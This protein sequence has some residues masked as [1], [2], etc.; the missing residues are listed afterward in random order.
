VPN[1]EFYGLPDTESTCHNSHTNNANLERTTG[2]EPA[3]LTLA[4]ASTPS[5]VFVEFV[6]CCPVRVWV[7][8]G[9]VLF[10]VFVLCRRLVVTFCDNR[11][12]ALSIRLKRPEAGRPLGTTRL[13]SAGARERLSRSEAPERW[14]P[15]SPARRSL[16]EVSVSER[17][18]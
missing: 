7:S 15:E 16:S 10:A 5:T 4:T 11:I 6:P 1:S 17:Y 13:Q 8:S 3:T 18:Q 14:S 9:G 2:F 12:G